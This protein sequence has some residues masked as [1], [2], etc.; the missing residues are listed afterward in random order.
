ML[1]ELSNDGQGAWFSSIGGR[2]RRLRSDD[3]SDL[4][5]ATVIVQLQALAAEAEA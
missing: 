3:S 5:D 4:P 2:N 1:I